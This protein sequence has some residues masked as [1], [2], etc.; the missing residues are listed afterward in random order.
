MLKLVLKEVRSVIRNWDELVQIDGLKA[1][2]SCVDAAT[3]MEYAITLCA[4]SER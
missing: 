3:E 2:K 4:M 1:G